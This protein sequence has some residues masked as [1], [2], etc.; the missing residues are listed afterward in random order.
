MKKLSV[1]LLSLMSCSC[2]Y[3]PVYDGKEAY[4]GGQFTLGQ[5]P[6][7]TLDFFLDGLAD[8]L[9]KSQKGLAP[10]SSLVIASFVDIENVERTNWLG[11][12]LTEGMMY[13]MQSRG[14]S[15][16][17][18]KSTGVIRVTKTGDFTLSRDWKE[19]PAEHISDHVLTGTML[20]QTGG[21][22]INVRVISLAS[23]VVVASAQGFLPEDRI[24]RDID[25]LYRVRLQ[26][27]SVIRSEQRKG[28]EKNIILKPQ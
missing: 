28:R 19:L 9:I 4:S 23:R 22:L 21:V 1:I 26:D 3:N 12:S 8:N 6:R 2:I 20:R 27:G 11:N 24:G 17:D 14:F 7:H 15:V 16:I 25:T 18:F 5:V 10:N 13:Q